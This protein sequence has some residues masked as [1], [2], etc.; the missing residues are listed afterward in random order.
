MRHAYR[1]GNGLHATANLM[2]VYSDDNPALTMNGWL[3][4]SIYVRPD[5]RGLGAGSRLLRDIIADADT[6]NVNLYLTIAADS[7]GG[8]TEDQLRDWYMRHGFKPIELGDQWESQ[9]NLER[10][11]DQTKVRSQEVSRAFNIV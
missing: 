10:I 2:H 1:D 3:I 6:E 8:L 7:S 5:Q 11:I 9:W 4:T